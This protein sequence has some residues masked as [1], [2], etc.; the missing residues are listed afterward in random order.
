MSPV[1]YKPEYT[2]M[3]CVRESNDW[4]FHD[5]VYAIFVGIDWTKSQTEPRWFVR[6]TKVYGNV[7][8][9]ELKGAN[10]TSDNV[11]LTKSGKYNEINPSEQIVLVQAMEHDNSSA[12][13]IKKLLHAVM[14]AN[15]VNYIGGIQTCP[16][17]QAVIEE[18]KKD[19]GKYIADRARSKMIEDTKEIMNKVI[20]Y[21]RIIP[22]SLITTSNLNNIKKTIRFA[23]LTGSSV[24]ISQILG[25]IDIGFTSILAFIAGLPTLINPDDK[26]G[27][28]QVLNITGDRRK[29]LTF[30]NSGK[31]TFKFTINTY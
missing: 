1:Q 23:N 14:E 5:E 10:N 12:T 24:G 9:G 17:L 22:G 4:G 11:N 8:K 18:V 13:G 28:P 25:A 27:A 29:Y 15:L 7:D 2:S 19:Y 26:V 3:E 30:S 31:Y 6:R 20:G 16:M 21:G